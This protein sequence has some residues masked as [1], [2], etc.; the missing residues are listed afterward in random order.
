MKNRRNLGVAAVTAAV[1]TTALVGTTLPDLLADRAASTVQQQNQNAEGSAASVVVTELPE[2]PSAKEISSAK[3]SSQA[4][5]QMISEINER[6][7]QA[8][9]RALELE[10]AVQMEH[11]NAL[12]AEQEAAE[13]AAAAEAAREAAETADSGAA[14]Q[15]AAGDTGA[16]DVLLS[17]DENAL[18]DAATE[19]RLEEQAESDAAQAEQE[20]SEAD[21]LAEQ[22]AQQST[23]AAEAA[24]AA[25]R[26]SEESAEHV[27][28][29]GERALELIEELA[30]LKGVPVEILRAQIEANSDFHDENGN[31]DPQQ[32]AYRIAQ[33]REMM[34]ADSED[35][36]SAEDAEDETAEDSSDDEEGEASSP[37]ES[38]AP[39]PADAELPAQSLD[40]YLEG[41]RELVQRL[42]ELED[43]DVESL[44]AELIE[45]E[46]FLDED[47]L[48]DHSAVLAR[49]YELE[50]EPEPEPEPEDEDEDAEGTED[51]DADDAAADETSAD[52]TSEEE[53]APA[54]SSHRLEDYL[55]GTQGLVERLAELEDTDVESLFAELIADDD[56]TDSDGLLDHA[57][58]QARVYELEPEPEPEPEEDEA[59]EDE[60]SDA[61][62]SEDE[63]AE[64]EPAQPAHRLDDYLPGTQGLVKEL[65]ELEDESVESMFAKLIDDSDFTDS[66]G[67]LDHSAIRARVAELTPEP[68]PEPEPE[69]ESSS[70]N[71]SNSSEES[72]PQPS[73]PSLDQYLPGTRSLVEELAE[74]EG[75]SASDM[76]EKLINDSDFTD[77]SGLLDHSAIRARV[78]ELTPEPEPEPEPEESSSSSSSDS[79]NSGSSN[80]GSSN[81][82]SSGSS[83]SQP[84]GPSLDQ[85]LP[86]TRALV[87]QLAELRGDGVQETFESVLG[88]SDLVGSNGVIDHAA[89]QREVNRLTPA[90]EPEPEPEPAPEESSS[91]SGSGSSDSG[92]SSSGSS[93]SG[94]G[95]QSVAA[96]S[97]SAAQIAVDFAVGKV[98]EPGTHYVLGATGPKAWDCSSLMQA[99]FAQAGIS[100]PRTAHQQ[101][102]GGQS[103]SLDNLQPGDIV[104]WVNGGRATH[105]AIYIG[106]GQVAHARNPQAGLSITS[107]Y[108]AYQDP[109]PVAKR[110]W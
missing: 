29:V 37:D 87:E 107:L 89:L 108:Y 98:N 59:S 42:A 65:A 35:E 2:V 43:T 7:S 39:D 21:A 50:P 38:E 101:F 48:L 1:V 83:S 103:V 6:L 102:Q 17:E 23:A 16:G 74:L 36:E 106:N 54:T 60:A 28:Q 95:S 96:G 47:G 97:S 3:E 33:L 66:D 20:S 52:E 26:Q 18:A 86:G 63:A 85:Y 84:T 53:D 67:L 62:A 13:A 19:Q 80:S 32:I 40:Q 11:Q 88:D 12:E 92:S 110:Y 45:D 69:E 5:D 79:S 91:S 73:G 15:Y 31:V 56:Y 55:P 44:F 76:F 49:V 41:T 24:E 9:Q 90:P 51:E 99:S 22:A 100:L 93:S 81:S 105:N 27:T 25:D 57:A 30:D 78:A 4:T 46:D 14:E 8:N 82:G 70:S 77:S 68:E 109:H 10:A 61:D 72:A 71:S 94:S 34:S 64:E 58:I 104:F 75:E